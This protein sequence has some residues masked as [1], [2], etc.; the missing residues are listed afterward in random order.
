M[1]QRK[2]DRPGVTPT[3]TFAFRIHPLCATLI[4]SVTSV[5]LYFLTII[6]VSIVLLVVINKK[7]NA[8][9]YSLHIPVPSNGVQDYI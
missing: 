4:R 5:Y 3:G 8:I 1:K 6:F 9:L 7:R 2:M